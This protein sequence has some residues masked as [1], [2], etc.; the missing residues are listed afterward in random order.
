MLLFLIL[1]IAAFA[2]IGVYAAQNPGVQ[3]VNLWQY[4]WTGIPQW[5]PVAT[6]A[7]VIALL[8][9]LYPVISS[10]LT[11]LRHGTLRRRIASHEAAMSDLQ[12]ENRSLREAN[13]RLESEVK[14]LRSL[15]DRSV[16]AGA[17][18]PGRFSA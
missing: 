18:Q 8:F 10:L 2:V 11:G 7:L 17:A 15:A 6:A 3:D 14:N 5:V 16:A 9:M 12:A 13:T 1:L 4:H